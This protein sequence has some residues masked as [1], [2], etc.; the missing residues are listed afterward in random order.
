MSRLDLDPVRRRGG[1]GN[2]QSA[3][4]AP[5]LVALRQQVG[6][7]PAVPGV[8]AGVEGGQADVAVVGLVGT[9]ARARPPRHAEVCRHHEVR[10]VTAHRPGQVP[11]QGKPVLDHPVA[12]A[13]ELHDVDTDRGRRR[14]L[15]GLR[16][17]PHS[18]G[19][20]PSM[21]AS[22]TVAST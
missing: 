14:P 20:S 11:A 5:R 3:T 9:A 1:S 7:H 2:G 18:A 15:L 22:P 12:V 13:E 16:A 8:P 19:G 6:E 4:A 17:G 21:P 10:A